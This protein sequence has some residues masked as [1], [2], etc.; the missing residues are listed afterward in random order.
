MARYDKIHL[1]F[2]DNGRERY[3]EAPRDGARQRSRCCSTC[4]RATATRGA[5]ACRVCY[6][7]RFPELYR[8]LCRAGRRPAAG[9]QRLHLHHRRRALGAAA[10]RARGREPGLGRWRRRR[11]ALHENGR[12]TWGQSMIVDPW[13][14]VVAQRATGEGVV[15]VDIDAARTRRVARAVAG[16]VARRALAHPETCPHRPSTQ[17]AP[18]PSR[19]PRTRLA[20]RVGGRPS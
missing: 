5:W 10:A 19:E 15:L 11:A 2:Y 17:P 16:A 3:D 1:F 20:I 6:D 13:G 14:K 9:A 12:H 7:L 4:H 8:A 18:R